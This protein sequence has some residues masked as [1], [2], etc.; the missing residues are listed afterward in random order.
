MLEREDLNGRRWNECA[1]LG[2]I[3]LR[4]CA[5]ETARQQPSLM[6]RV[7]AVNNNDVVLERLGGR[8]I[9]LAKSEI[10]DIAES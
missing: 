9:A 6:G 4:C 10:L 3:R 5:A 8:R 7:L 2:D 1:H